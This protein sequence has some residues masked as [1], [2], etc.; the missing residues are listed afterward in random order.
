MRERASLGSACIAGQEFVGEFAHF[1][2]KCYITGA[3]G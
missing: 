2:R 1:V 3:G